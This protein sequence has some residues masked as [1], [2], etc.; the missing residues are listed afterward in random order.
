[1]LSDASVLPKR[2]GPSPNKTAATRRALAQA[3]LAVFIERGFSATK[4]SDVAAHAQVAKG[5]IYLHFNDKA[6]LFE[7]VLHEVMRETLAGRPMPRPRHSET[8]RSFLERVLLPI[9]RDLQAN[10]RFAVVRLVMAEGRYFPE[11][12]TAY[13]RIAIDPVL[14]IVRMLA[15]RIPAR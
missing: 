3:A 13:R 11:V 8:T 2:R 15:K 4:M 12:A 14:R 1:M 7:D 10:G 6:A 5:T 9:L